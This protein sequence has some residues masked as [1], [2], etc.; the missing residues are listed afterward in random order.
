MAS[1]TQ[2]NRLLQVST[3]LG[4]DVLL[5][6][7]VS[8]VEGVSL[9]FHFVLDLLSEDESVSADALLRKPA[10]IT[11]DQVGGGKRRIHG[12]ISRFVQLGKDEDLVHYEAELVPWL[13]FLTLSRECEIF[14]GKTVPEI[15][16]DV[17]RSQ[18][19]GDFEI[20]CTKIYGTRDYCVRY[21]ETNFDLVSRLMEEEGIF[22]FFEQR[23]QLHPTPGAAEAYPREDGEAEIDGG[24]FE[25]VHRLLQFQVEG[26][27]RVQA[28]CLADQH[29]CEVGEDPPVSLLVDVGQGTEEGWNR[30]HTE[31]GNG[32]QRACEAIG[33]DLCDPSAATLPRGP[34][35]I[36]RSHVG[37]EYVFA[38]REV[39]CRTGRQASA[40]R[41]SE[42]A[43]PRTGRSVP[44]GAFLQS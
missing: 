32:D 3:P 6:S 5:A 39:R 2:A 18:R 22:Y 23:G 31:V 17:F 30:F 14:Q 28:T 38:V 43:E 4:P 9:P 42:C 34:R 7:S 33:R 35:D 13:W 44:V 36:C 37:T 27:V 1:Y 25:S 11:I 16:E 29:L 8:G 19:N 10:V 40:C 26:I 20:R 24:G 12:L 21:R 41:S 15:V